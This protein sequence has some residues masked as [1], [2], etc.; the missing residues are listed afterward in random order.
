MDLTVMS[1]CMWIKNYTKN[2]EQQNK[3]PHT[4][5]WHKIWHG[6]PFWEKS[7]ARRW[8]LPA[9]FLW[10]E[11]WLQVQRSMACGQW[12]TTVHKSSLYVIYPT[13]LS[14][15]FLIYEENSLE[16]WAHFPPGGPI[17]TRLDILLVVTFWL[18][19][20]LTKVTI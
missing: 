2:I 14:Y 18:P 12:V 1:A 11:T 4:H 6:K 7:L 3:S 13:P 5:I 8:G 9:L 15:F 17:I 10:M 20:L 19:Q 16:E